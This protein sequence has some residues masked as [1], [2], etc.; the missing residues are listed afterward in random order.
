MGQPVAQGPTHEVARR[1]LAIVPEGRG[2]FY[3]LTVAENLRLRRHRAVDGRRRRRR[4]PYFPAL[5][6]S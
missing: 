5:D 2:L 6:A 1:G 3:K 4:S